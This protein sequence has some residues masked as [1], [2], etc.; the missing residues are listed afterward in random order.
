MEE[1]QQSTTATIESL[2]IKAEIARFLRED[3]LQPKLDK[4]DDDDAEG[5]KKLIDEHQP[6]IWIA[7][8]AR[9]VSQIQQV[10]H[11]VKFTHPSA[12]GSGI[13][14]KGNHFATDAELG[15]HTLGNR[16]ASDVVGNAAALDV[17]KF[18]QLSI[19]GRTLLA[20]AIARDQA[21]SAALSADAKQ[22]AAWMAAFAT[23]PDAKS[24]PASHQ[25]TRQLYWPIAEN[26]YH[27]LA[28]LFSSSLAHEVY[29]RIRNDRFSDAAKAAREARKLNKAHP[30]GYRDYPGHA[31]Q[32]FGGSKPQNISQLNSERRGENYLLASL[33][34]T[35]KSPETRPPLK[36]ETIFDR[37]FDRR[38]EVRRLVGVLKNFL[39]RASDSG[40]N[41][42]IR[43]TRAELVADLCGEALQ[44]AAE[45]REF[46]APGWTSQPDCQL[47]LA[48]QC[49]LDPERRLNDA[50]FASQY[51]QCDWR[52][53]VSLRF[54]NWLNAR[55]QTDRTSFG[56]AEGLAWQEALQYE[57]LQLREEM[58]HE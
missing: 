39:L 56:A 27:I 9:R 19:G 46:Q 13:Y 5:R 20:R 24:S 57:L 3:R 16:L 44:T 53:E 45:L 40:S 36:T 23:L 38:P 55:L 50:N 17:H 14:S 11:S 21:L 26:S 31:I 42:R 34:P 12:D 8:A 4:L 2:R 47:N 33:P 7:S 1:T 35:W 29:F 18:L 58:D 30:H 41:I 6:D 43:E 49:W 28:P 32:S 25:L 15:S 48:E 37:H 54:A 22:A 52:D 10:T 51:Q